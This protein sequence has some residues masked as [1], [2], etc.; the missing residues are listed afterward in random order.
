MRLVS[1]D[2]SAYPAYVTKYQARSKSAGLVQ[3]GAVEKTR[4]STGS[5]PQRPQRCAS[6]NSATTAFRSKSP[7]FLIFQGRVTYQ[8]GV[9]RKSGASMIGLPVEWHMSSGATEYPLALETMEARRR[10][11]GRRART[12][13]ARRTP[14][15][16]HRR[17]QFPARRPAGWKP[18]PRIHRRS[19]WG[20]HLSRTGTAGLLCN[21]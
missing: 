19:G 4:T 5:L 7:F 15:A 8:I 14:A 1:R 6:T 11:R 16:I 20:V 18:V 21:D 10:D 9:D 12:H 3:S 2:R 17:N 13:L